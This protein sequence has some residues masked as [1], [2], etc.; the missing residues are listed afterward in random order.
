MNARQFIAPTAREAM[1]MARKALGPDAV[2]LNNRKTSKG[3]CVTAMQEADLIQ[4][5][6]AGAPDDA[7]FNHS[8]NQ[9]EQAAW[10]SADRRQPVAENS[11]QLRTQVAAQPATPEPMSTVSFQRY[12]N[13]RRARTPAT[14]SESPGARSNRAV[15]S[16][17]AKPGAESLPEPVRAPVTEQE[18]RDWAASKANASEKAVAN[19]SDPTT[20]L[21]PTVVQEETASE[22]I[23]MAAE[24]RQ[25]RSFISQQFSALSWVDGVRRTPG[26]AQVLRRLLQAG[27]SSPLARSLVGHLPEGYVGQAADDWLAQALARNLNAPD[28]TDNVINAGGVFALVGPT[29]VGKTTSVAKIAARCALEHGVD[30]VGLITADAYRVGAQDQLRRFGSMIGITVHTAHDAQ[31]LHGLLGLLQSKRIVLIDTAGLGQ[32][33]PRVTM[34][35]DAVSQGPIQRLLVLSAAAQIESIREAIESYEGNDC[36]GVLLTKVDEACR[37]GGALDSLIRFRLPLLAVANGQRVPED[38]HDADVDSLV[39]NALTSSDTDDAGL[40]DID[41]T[42]LMQRVDSRAS[43][44]GSPATP[45]SSTIAGAL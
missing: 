16:A 23:A 15:M 40:P 6:L 39:R 26:Q 12:A 14:G 41:L 32:R 37:L 18:S 42:M 4:L 2:I 21:T 33:D 29:G 3:I 17:P 28:W 34:L 27:F 20:V 19:R 35:V 11:Q 43:S 24:L 25:M 7:E 10:D 31:S 44:S 9:H 22:L 38:W 13:E 5:D 1:A 36:A 45:A 30:E 8:V